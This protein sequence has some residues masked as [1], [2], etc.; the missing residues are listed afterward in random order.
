VSAQTEISGPYWRLGVWAFGRLGVQHA[1]YATSSPFD[2]KELARLSGRA[3]CLTCWKTTG[4]RCKGVRSGT[5]WMK[6]LIQPLFAI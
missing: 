3:G 2:H 5:P 4:D 6:N 1:E